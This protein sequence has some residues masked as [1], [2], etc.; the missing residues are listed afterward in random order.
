MLDF[1][2]YRVGQ[3]PW[4]KLVGRTL[5]KWQQDDCLEMGAALSYYAVFSLFP[6]ILVVLSVISFLIGPSTAAFDTV[7]HFAQEVLPPDAFPIIQTTLLRFHQGSTRASL[8]GFTILLFTASGFFGALSRSFDKI[9][10]VDNH[11]RSVKWVPGVALTFLWRRFLAFLLVIGSAG[12]VFISLLSNIV[13]DTL[14]RLLAR[15]STMLTIETIDWVQLLPSLQIGVSFIILILV[16]GV[17]YKVLPRTYVAWGDLWLGALF[18]AILWL[19]LQQLITNSVISLG[20][21]FQSYGVVSSFMV[22]MLWIY[23]TSQIF[24]LGGEIT[25]VYAHL[26]GSRRHYKRINPH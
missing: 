13:I 7:M 9:W 10:R 5:L 20:S 25:Y 4:V 26:F 19:M 15:F 2:K 18:T 21:R 11:H 24:F 6:M 1:V 23:L 16:V 17:L 12:L 8:I 3:S 14:L 22:L